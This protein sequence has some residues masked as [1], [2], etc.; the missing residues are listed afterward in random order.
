MGRCPQRSL[1]DYDQLIVAELAAGVPDD[2]DVSSGC[3]YVV[4]A[5]AVANGDDQWL[6]G[7]GCFA[8]TAL[9]SRA[10]GEAC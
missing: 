2:G 5:E 1:A 7:F 8:N 9:S 4:G 3:D 6:A 10:P